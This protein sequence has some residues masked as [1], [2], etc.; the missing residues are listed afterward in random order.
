MKL[1]D[2]HQVLANKSLLRDERLGDDPLALW[3]A[4]PCEEMVGTEFL[5]I[6]HE[7]NGLETNT[8]TP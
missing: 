5:V 4:A 8:N 1:A 6:D 7:R 2:R 3:S